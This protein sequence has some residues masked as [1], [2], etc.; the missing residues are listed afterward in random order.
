MS[1]KRRETRINL[2]IPGNL[3]TVEE[4]L[5]DLAITL[6]VL[7]Q[8]GLPKAAVKRLSRKMKTLQVYQRLF[9]KY[10]R[11]RKLELEMIKLARK[12]EELAMQ[13]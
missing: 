11:Y 3:P 9:R 5:W 6:E 10:V 8:P 13:P 1:S 7:S 12:Y 2:D 4:N